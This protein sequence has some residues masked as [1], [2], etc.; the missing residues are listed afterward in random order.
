M[1][2]LDFSSAL[3]CPSSAQSSIGDIAAFRL[4]YEVVFSYQLSIFVGA[5]GKD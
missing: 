5:H 2:S 3:T 1:I 4:C